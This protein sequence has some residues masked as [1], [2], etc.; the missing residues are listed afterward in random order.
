M[1]TPASIQADKLKIL[2]RENMDKQLAGPLA[3]MKGLEDK[4]SM[5]KKLHNDTYPPINA[6][7][8][9]LD[10]MAMSDT[11]SGNPVGTATALTAIGSNEVL[12]RA[13]KRL[14]DEYAKI[15]LKV[16]LPEEFAKT[17]LTGELDYVNENF[18]TDGYFDGITDGIYDFVPDIN[19][20]E[21]A[22]RELRESGAK[23][24][25]E[26]YV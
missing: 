8:G 15:K 9:A 23:F 21:D 13:L 7:K 4:F 6:L 2:A 22:D 12:V 19:I 1:A 26:R 14:S 17:K 24:D 3:T 25:Y 10:A 18:D 5:V 16:M 20:I 11:G